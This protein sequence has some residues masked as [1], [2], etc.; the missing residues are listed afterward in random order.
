MGP[1]GVHEAGENQSVNNGVQVIREW[2]LKDH[3]SYGFGA[4]IPE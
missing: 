1:A 4:R 2:G 3:I